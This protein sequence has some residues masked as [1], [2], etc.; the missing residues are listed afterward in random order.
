MFYGLD[1]GGGKIEIALFNEQLQ[2]Q[3]SWR[4]DTPTSE[5]Q[6]FIDTVVQ[7]V[8]QADAQTGKIGRVGIG[9]PGVIDSNNH[10]LTANIPCANGKDVAGDLKQ[11]LDRPIAIEND[12]R[13]FVGCIGLSNIFT[14]IP[15]KK[16]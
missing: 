8:E 11:R 15:F 12:S 4:V 7:L 1:I 5:Y 6:K 14:F 3:H 2:I 9:L 13:C 16:H 10:L